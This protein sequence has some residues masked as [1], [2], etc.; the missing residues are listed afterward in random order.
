MWDTDNLRQLSIPSISV[1]SARGGR[2]SKV[3]DPMQPYLPLIN[4]PLVPSASQRG[5][6][7]MP[8]SFPTAPVTHIPS[9]TWFSPPPAPVENSQ[10]PTLIIS[11]PL[12][13]AINTK[14]P[15]TESLSPL[16]SSA[17][18]HGPAV[19]LSST[20]S[21]AAGDV[22]ILQQLSST[23]ATAASEHLSRSSSVQSGPPIAAPTGEQAP[24]VPSFGHP[25]VSNQ[26]FAQESGPPMDMEEVSLCRL[27]AAWVLNSECSSSHPL[28]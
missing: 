7:S 22:I 28:S 4:S 14:P 25:L 9:S 26:S 24:L 6:R 10:R 17:N 1:G 16:P 12:V 23:S 11:L 20:T 8:L 5:R 15:Q 2:L 21:L 27:F 13:P 3:R 18:D 19:S